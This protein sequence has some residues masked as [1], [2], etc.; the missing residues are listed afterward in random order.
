MRQT[1]GCDTAKLGTL[2]SSEKAIAAL[3]DRW[4]SQT[5]EEEEDKTAKTFYV[6]NGRNVM[7]VQKLEGSLFGVGTVLHLQRNAWSIVK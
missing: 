1:D 4:W 6:S 3:G 7:R 2:D 5:A